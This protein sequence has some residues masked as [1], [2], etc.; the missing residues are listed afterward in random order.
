MTIA[1]NALSRAQFDVS[2]VIRR[3]QGDLVG[4][5]GLNPSECPYRT[6][7]SRSHW[8]LRDHARGLRTGVGN[9]AVM[10]ACRQGAGGGQLRSVGRLTF[11]KG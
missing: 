3:A 11:G 9:V 1:L 6:I 2:D 10:A 4:A 7:T 8:R 5:F